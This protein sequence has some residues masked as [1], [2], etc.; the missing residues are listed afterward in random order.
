MPSKKT[1]SGLTT[2]GLSDEYLHGFTPKEQRRLYKQAKILE[3]NIYSSVDFSG[4]SKILEV[5][6]GVGAQTEILIKRFPH[7]SVTGLDAS[8]AQVAQAK[9]YLSAQIEKK[10]VEFKIG[11]ALKMPF[12]KA[13]FDGA[14]VC[15]FLEHVSAPVDILRE[16]HR[17]LRPSG[18]IICN[19][20]MNSTF[21]IHPYSPATL[22]YWFHFNDHQWY[23]KGD[24][25]VG[26][27]L[28]NYL[29]S[30]G[31]RNVKLTPKIEHCDSRDERHRAIIIDYWTELLL[32]G[33]PGLLKAKKV[34]NTLVIE[35]SDELKTLK[36]DRNS[37]FF[38]AFMQA[39]AYA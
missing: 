27:K 18:K 17:C 8:V 36:K 39:E 26:A 32:S 3:E 20:V 19:E 4:Q 31:F 21:F 9:K 11:D 28:G 25:F 24:P 35:M 34:T 16:I 1:G 5:G 29:T 12:G 2:S 30:A 38:Y 23:S 13:E 22:T 14:Y 7:I 15:W 37:T 6:C 33:A 10:K